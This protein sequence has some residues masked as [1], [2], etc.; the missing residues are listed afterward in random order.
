MAIKITFKEYPERNEPCVYRIWFGK[1]F[2]IGRSINILNRIKQHERGLNI[3]ILQNNTTSGVYPLI[4][5]HIIDKNITEAVLEI[6]E[7]SDARSVFFIEQ[8]RLREFI[9]SKKC[10]N[11]F[12]ASCR[13]LR[14]IYEDKKNKKLHSLNTL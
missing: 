13:E 12:R 2:Y 10:L 7:Y 3:A 4:V 1:R 8:Y 11:V 14:A 5:K 6:I 9:G